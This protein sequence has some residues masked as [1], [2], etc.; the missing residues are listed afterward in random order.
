MGVQDVETHVL[1]IRRRLQCVLFPVA[2]GVRLRSSS[3]DSRS[4]Q[5]VSMGVRT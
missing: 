5:L 1:K 2:K 4:V 3:E